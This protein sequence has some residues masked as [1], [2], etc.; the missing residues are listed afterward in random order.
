MGNNDTGL[1]NL[2]LNVLKKKWDTPWD[3]R[4]TLG[5][6]PPEKVSTVKPRLGH[7]FLNQ[8]TRLTQ[9]SHCPSP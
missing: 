5:E 6:T 4:G 1:R 3:T 7:L 8:I 2:A 9:L